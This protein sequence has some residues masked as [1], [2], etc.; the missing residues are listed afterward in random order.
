MRIMRNICTYVQEALPLDG[1]DRVVAPRVYNI[2]YEIIERENIYAP[3]M[4]CYWCCC[5]RYVR[6]VCCLRFSL[7]RRRHRLAIKMRDYVPSI[8]WTRRESVKRRHLCV[9]VCVWRCRECNDDTTHAEI[10]MTSDICN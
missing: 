1:L 10:T 3:A 6:Y 9:S 4:V 8:I 7:L 2:H 5:V